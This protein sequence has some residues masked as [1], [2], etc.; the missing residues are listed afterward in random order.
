MRE[1][2]AQLQV[3]AAS[4][5]RDPDQTA[6][7]LA[8]HPTGRYVWAEA[9]RGSALALPEGDVDIPAELSRLEDDGFAS[10]VVLGLRGS[11]RMDEVAEQPNVVAQK[12]FGAYEV[13]TIEFDA[14]T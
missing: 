1:A 3:A 2:G 8:Q 9:E 10:V 13:I 4:V 5:E 11:D 7:L 14:G 6:L 12:D